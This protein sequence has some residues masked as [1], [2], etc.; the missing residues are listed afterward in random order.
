MAKTR[1]MGIQGSLAAS[2]ESLSASPAEG[3][4]FGS[5]SVALL[6]LSRP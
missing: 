2:R 5:L 6:I 3:R 4:P 1:Q